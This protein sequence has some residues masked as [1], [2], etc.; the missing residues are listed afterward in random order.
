MSKKAFLV[1]LAISCGQ[2]A[3]AGEDLS[4][5]VWYGLRDAVR[6]QTQPASQ[7]INPNMNQPL[8]Q[9]L[10][11]QQIPVQQQV[12]QPVGAS[13]QIKQRVQQE[14]TEYVDKKLGTNLSNRNNPLTPSNLNQ[15]N[16]NINPNQIPVQN[17]QILP[18][19]QTANSSLNSN[20]KNLG[21]DMQDIRVPD[22]YKQDYYRYRDKVKNLI[23]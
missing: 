1:L 20:L 2:P 15:I 6:N 16:Q 9:P 7:A 21:V 23:K 14:V 11:A 18:G 8:T 4:K 12:A 3:F 17:N 5:K 13:G 22:K 19:G 10:G